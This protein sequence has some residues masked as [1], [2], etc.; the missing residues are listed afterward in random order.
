MLDGDQ[1][2]F[3]DSSTATEDE[4]AGNAA[5]S[6]HPDED[7][8]IPQPYH[9]DPA[10]QRILAQRN[11]ARAKAASYDALGATPEQISD[12]GQELLYYRDLVARAK[13]SQSEDSRPATP[14]EK[15]E[16]AQLK[17]AR[18]AL[19]RVAPELD[20]IANLKQALKIIG[21]QVESHYRGLESQADDALTALMKEAGL[22]T[23]S[24]DVR[25]NANAMVE[26]IKSDPKLYQ[27]YLR[28]PE[29]AVKKAWSIYVE[30]AEKLTSR[31]QKADL[32]TTGATL[33]TLPRAQGGGGLPGGG[34]TAPGT[35]QTV[36]D[37]FREFRAGLLSRKG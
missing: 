18:A 26:E 9:K 25:R 16:E 20:E 11:E 7:D 8:G 10:W 36:D 31:R 32:Q 21:G 14:E 12:L 1:D 30:R 33:R 17:A 29:G 34:S 37:A 6:G 2:G 19:K 35:P 23:S 22:P 5:G 27:K 24:A 4:L 28:D 3:A 13:A 15:D